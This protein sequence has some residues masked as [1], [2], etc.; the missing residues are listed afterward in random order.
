M[1]DLY[2]T[3]FRPIERFLEEAFERAL[4]FIWKMI[5]CCVPSNLPTECPICFEEQSPVHRFYFLKTKCSKN[6]ANNICCHRC[7]RSWMVK[8]PATNKCPF[9]RMKIQGYESV[10]DIRLD[11]FFTTIMSVLITLITY[12]IIHVIVVVTHHCCKGTDLVHSS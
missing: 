6:C 2:E 8:A 4:H 7:L 12:I 1:P 3:Y 5:V 11:I 9:C 10:N